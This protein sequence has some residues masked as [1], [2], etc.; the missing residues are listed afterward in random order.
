MARPP[1]PVTERPPTE[2]E[3]AM[4]ELLRAH[5]Q[6]L[7][8]DIGVRNH[9]EYRNLEA[10]AVWIAQ[11]FKEY[12]Y[13]VEWQEIRGEHENVVWNLQAVLRGSDS[14]EEAIVIGA[15]YDSAPESPGANDNGS[16]VAALL[17]LAQ[18]YAGRRPRRTLRFVAFANEETPYFQTSLMGSVLYA[19][20][21][22]Q[23][24][25]RIRLM[26]CLE[27]IGYYSQ[28]PHTQTY[29]FPLQFFYPDT[30]NF[31]AFVGNLKSREELAEATRAFRDATD[32]PC[33]SGA[34]PK[35]IPGVSASDHWAFWRNNYP[36]IMITDTANFRY[37]QFHS[38]DDT[39]DKLSYPEFARVVMGISGMIDRL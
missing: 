23:R 5:V 30:A 3:R 8:G 34:V 1:A 10:A 19:N 12:G 31:V 18:L 33:L 16:G 28:A 36:A 35:W 15:H 39:P 25:D 7:A 26:I 2:A 22:R 29:P 4:E 32:F 37:L 9:V 6:V 38:V 20:Q 14:P 13:E 24:G 11:C 27:T 21:C 17:A